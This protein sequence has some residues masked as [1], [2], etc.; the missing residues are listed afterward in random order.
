MGIM[1]AMMCVPLSAGGGIDWIDAAGFAVARSP[2]SQG[3]LTSLPARHD[4]ELRTVPNVEV[5]RTF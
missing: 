4:Y 2:Y 1:D 5:V 3:L